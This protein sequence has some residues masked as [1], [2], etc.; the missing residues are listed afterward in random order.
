MSNGG[1][2]IGFF[3]DSSDSNSMMRLVWGICVVGVVIVWGVIS[4]RTNTIQAV[5]V[6]TAVAFMG[7]LGSKVVQKWIEGFEQKK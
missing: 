7:L 1:E 4:I 6:G 3:Q 5:D 2:K